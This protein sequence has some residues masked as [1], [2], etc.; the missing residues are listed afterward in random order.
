MP[1]FISY[2]HT[3]RAAALRINK[4]LE[5]KQI[6]TYL[7][8]MDSESQTTDDITTVISRNIIKC[9]HLIALVSDDTAQSWWVP[10]EIGEATITERR[11]A[12]FQIDA[13][14]LP[15]Y[16]D[17]WPIMKKDSDL[18]LF[19]DAYTI[20]RATFASKRSVSMEGFESMESTTGATLTKGSADSFHSALKRKIRLGG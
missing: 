11:I 13:A 19:I 15:D 10:F 2:R 4:R 20:D 17:K 14:K 9:S 8:V 6:T 16:L 7:D 18:D 3:D 5:A 1:V 12:T